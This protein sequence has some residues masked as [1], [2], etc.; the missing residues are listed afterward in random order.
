MA[1]HYGII[2]VWMQ[3]PTPKHVNQPI[4]D[5]LRRW[6]GSVEKVTAD[7]PVEF[8]IGAMDEAG[9]QVGLICA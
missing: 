5:S 1:E 6:T 4:F 3:H 8:T 2:D 9:V 7:I